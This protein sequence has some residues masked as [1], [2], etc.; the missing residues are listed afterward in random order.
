MGTGFTIDTPLRVAKY[1]INSVIALVDDDLIEK[2]R[3]LYADKFGEAYQEITSQDEDFRAKRITAYLNLAQKIVLRQIQDLKASMFTPDSELT[4]YYEMLPDNAL[5]KSYQ[6][7]LAE[8]DAKRKKDLQNDLCN[9][10]EPGSIDVNIMTKMDRQ[11]YRCDEILPYEFCDAAAAMRGFANSNLSSSVILSAGFNPL[12]YGYM[13]QFKDFYPDVNNQLKK[14]ICLKVSDF[15]SAIIQG[16][17]L[18]KHGLWVTEYRIE[19]P[20]NCGGHAFINDGQLLGSI[21]EEFKQRKDELREI[22]HGFYKKS[23]N[24]NNRLCADDP[25]EIYLTAQGGIGTNA[26]QEFLLQHYGLQAVGWG[27]PFLLVPEA[28]SVDQQQLDKL[29]SA[30]SGD[31][32]LSAASPLG[33]PIWNLRNSS[34]ELARFQRISAG[35]PG[36]VCTKGYAKFNCEFTSKPICRASCEYQHYKLKE[37]KAQQPE[38]T[39]EKFAALE[40]DILSKACICND[41][42]GGALIK[43]DIDT[44]ALSAICPGPNIINFKKIATLKEMVDHIYGRCSLLANDSRPHMFIQEVRL[45]I[46]YFLSELKNAS[47]GLP[48]RSQQKLAEVKENISKGIQYYQNLTKEIFHEQCD[49]FSETLQLLQKE[50]ADLPV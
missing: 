49:K 43:H 17:Y 20:I 26:E 10:I 34:S 28:T 1:G 41:L 4:R 16:K 35:K 11:N 39:Q 23:L 40:A 48:A 50:V 21:L 6:L 22:L 45:Q 37:L 7:M 2:M 14:K 32:F 8:Q 44:Q 15:R 38:F 18:A 29:I 9:F 46:D 24:N 25:R 33:I 13:T 31:I 30:K 36:S 12:L 19:S 3:R 27:S 42:A 5:K 47:L